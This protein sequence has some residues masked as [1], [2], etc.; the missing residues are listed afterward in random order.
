MYGCA[1]LTRG[2]NLLTRSCV[3]DSDI[4][5][6]LSHRGD[7]TMGNKAAGVEHV[8]VSL[9][10]TM[11]LDAILRSLGLLPARDKRLQCR[12]RYCKRKRICVATLV[13]LLHGAL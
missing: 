9:L 5:L 6:S 11:M 7:W 13:L 8:L 1:W 12:T 2:A 10:D 3:A 4:N